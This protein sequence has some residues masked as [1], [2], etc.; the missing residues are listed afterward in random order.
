[1]SLVLPSRLRPYRE[2]GFDTMIVELTASYDAE[3]IERLA[4]EV[5]SLVEG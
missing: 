2:L 5:V 1:M 3:T 4:T